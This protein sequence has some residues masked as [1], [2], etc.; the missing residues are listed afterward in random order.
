MNKISEIENERLFLTRIADRLALQDNNLLR[1]ETCQQSD[2]LTQLK[3]PDWIL[4]H[5][6]LKNCNP[7]ELLQ[8]IQK[9]FKRLTLP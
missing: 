7:L 5:H 8:P 2:P 6:R 3:A 4:F 1:A 9:Q